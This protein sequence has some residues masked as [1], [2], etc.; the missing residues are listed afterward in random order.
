M[1]LNIYNINGELIKTEKLEQNQQ[2]FG[3]YDFKN[4]VYILEIKSKELVEK[5]KLIIQR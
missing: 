3:L 2:K 5:Q 4:G 1:K